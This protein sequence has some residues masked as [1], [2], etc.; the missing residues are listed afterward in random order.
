[1][2]FTL[3]LHYIFEIVNTYSY[4]GVIFK[5]NGTFSRNKEIQIVEQAEKTLYCVY[6]LIRK[7][8]LPLYIQLLIF[9]SM[10]EP[11][12]IYG[13]EVWWYEN[14]KFIEQI[15]LKFC[16]RVLQVR[17]TPLNFMVLGEFARV[18]FLKMTQN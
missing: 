6:K 4:L 12:L 17:K 13:S 18:T 15:H 8:A 5:Y 7:E 11:V 1:M 2:D 16:K 9:D 10:I 14:L 3:H